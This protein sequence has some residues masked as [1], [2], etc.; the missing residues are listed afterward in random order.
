MAQ[1]DRGDPRRI[2]V[3][4][5]RAVRIRSPLVLSIVRLRPSRTASASSTSWT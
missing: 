3:V 5:L 1:Q 4:A 2:G